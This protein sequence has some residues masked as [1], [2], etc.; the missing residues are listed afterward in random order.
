MAEY[1]LSSQMQNGDDIRALM[2]I[3]ERQQEDHQRQREMLMRIESHILRVQSSVGPN[4]T[5]GF[6]KLVDATDHSHA[7]PMDVCDSFE[8]F[9]EQLQLL[10]KYNSIEARIQRRYMEQGQYDLVIDD[11]RTITRLTSHEWPSIEAGTT[12]V[13]RVVFEQQTSPRVDF[14]CHFCDAV[15]DVGAGSIMDSLERQ[16]GCSIDCRVCKRRFQISRGSASAK[17]N[18]QSSNIDPVPR[19][20]AEMHLIRNFLV[21]QI[22][23]QSVKPRNDHPRTMLNNELQKKYGSSAPMHVAWRVYSQGPPDN[24]TWHAT[25]YIDDMNYG[26][27]TARTSGGAQDRAANMASNYLRRERSS[28]R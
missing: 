11:D 12:I 4:I 15:N 6:V 16:A 9:K 22:N 18:S 14:R 2:A 19:T 24:L 7:I 23:S 28:R 20:E 5:L 13:M 25:V 17:R 3:L 1:L 27:A 8:R 26:Y 21:Q 10:F